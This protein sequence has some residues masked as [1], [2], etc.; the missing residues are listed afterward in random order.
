[1]GAT[2]ISFATFLLF[3]FIM[4][5]FWW[6][7]TKYEKHQFL[8]AWIM[9][10]VCFSFAVVSESSCMNGLWGSFYIVIGLIIA[11]CAGLSPWS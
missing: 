4:I 1:M 6:S 11:V 9:V 10:V 5:F 8:I 2:M 7:I 3:V